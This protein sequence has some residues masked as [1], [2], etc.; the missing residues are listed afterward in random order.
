MKEKIKI[1]CIGCG[2]ISSTFH[3]PS[4]AEMEDE[5]VLSVEVGEKGEEVEVYL[6]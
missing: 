4:L 2:Y 5:D 1:C 3:Y 6:G